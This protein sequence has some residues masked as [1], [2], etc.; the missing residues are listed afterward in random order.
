MS[1]PRGEGKNHHVLNSGDTLSVNT[2]ATLGEEI[3]A[4]ADFLANKFAREVLKNKI[5]T[6]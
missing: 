2:G 5:Q 3:S 1:V 6:N 4:R